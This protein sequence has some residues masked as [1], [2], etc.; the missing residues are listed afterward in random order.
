[1]YR[2]IMIIGLGI[3][4][5]F[6]RDPYVLHL[7]I[8]F[9]MWVI[10]GEAWNLLGGYCGQASFGHAAFFGLGAYGAGLL[11]LKL[12]IST[13]FGL[14]TGPFLAVVVAIPIGLICLRLRGPYFALSMLA[15]AEVLRLIFTNWRAM[16]NGPVGILIIPSFTS[17]IPF[18]YI[19]FLLA[20]AATAIVSFVIRSKLGYYFMAIREDQDAAAA[21]GINTSL[22]K[23]I[24]L[25]ISAAFTG[26][27]GAFYM[28]YLGYIDPPIVF[29]L[30]DISIGMILV[31]MIG[32]AG[33]FDGPIL[34]ALVMVLAGEGFRLAFGQAHVLIYGIM[35]VLII[36]FAPR[37]LIG[38]LGSRHA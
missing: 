4:P 7:A 1:M 17:K 3:L 31:V 27:A 2:I 38:S 19:I 28:N 23:L 14:I 26:L 36:V 11:L 9:L 20:V 10:L 32:G 34:G 24:A 22:Y 13:W 5:I 37:G 16:T 30:V 25:L 29:S 8:M 12:H 21:I 33:T 15:V 18:Y 35:I 6:V